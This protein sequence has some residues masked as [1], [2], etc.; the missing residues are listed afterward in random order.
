MDPFR[1]R[2]AQ[3]FR[4]KNKGHPIRHSQRIP[5]EGALIEKSAFC[6]VDVL[7][8]KRDNYRKKQVPSCQRDHSLDRKTKKCYALRIQLVQLPYKKNSASR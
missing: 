6:I 4:L 7:G 3:V 8:H 5:A 1:R 2:R